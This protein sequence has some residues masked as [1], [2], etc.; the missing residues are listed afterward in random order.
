MNVSDWYVAKVLPKG[1]T[2]FSDSFY[3]DPRIR[4]KDVLVYVRQLST[5]SPNTARIQLCNKP[6]GMVRQ[7]APYA[8]AGC[9][10]IV[11]KAS[12]KESQELSL[13]VIE[14]KLDIT[15][16]PPRRKNYVRGPAG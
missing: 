11:R 14:R 10:D 5:D 1:L 4:A 13:G 8:A 2:F 7:L 6:G 12:R 9:F 16:D 15:V 3:P